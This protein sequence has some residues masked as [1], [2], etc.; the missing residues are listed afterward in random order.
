MKR[1]SLLI[2]FASMTVMSI[3]QSSRII[4]DKNVQTRNVK[5]FHAIQV[6]GGIDLY[7]SQ[8]DEAVAVSSNDLD[9]RDRIRT[10][11]ENG[12]LKIYLDHHD[13]FH[14]GWHNLKMKAYVSAKTLDKLG[15]SGGSDIN[16]EGSIKSDKLDVNLSGGSDLK[17]KLNVTDL[18][19]DQSGGSDVDISGSVTNLDIDASGGS[20]F[21]GYDLVTDNC[22]ISSSGG[23]DAQLNVNKELSAHAS[24]GSDISYK[25]NGVI[26]ELKS[27][28]SSSVSKRG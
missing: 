4:N 25:G 8:G 5:G 10:E 28:G 24:G 3:A 15:A 16:I 27:S 22:H 23:S 9:V 26:K 6:S 7:L 2:V 1:I 21:H 14:W 11:V 17:G 19:I 18:G 20:D 12:V 13:G